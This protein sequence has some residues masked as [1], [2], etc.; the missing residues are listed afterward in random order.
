MWG[1][2][3]PK[4]LLTVIFF[5]TP[6]EQPNQVQIFCVCLHYLGKVS[7]SHSSEMKGTLEKNKGKLHWGQID[8]KDWLWV[9][10]TLNSCKKKPKVPLE[11]LRCN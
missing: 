3:E 8:P 2:S 1:Q 9:K 10:K 5:S 11:V 4:D 6:L 7:E